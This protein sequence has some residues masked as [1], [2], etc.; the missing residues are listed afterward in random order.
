MPPARTPEELDQLL[1]DAIL[2][3][4]RTALPQ[5]FEQDALCVIGGPELRGRRLIARSLLE[6]RYVA[7]Q[8]H[9]LQRGGMALV[10]G[11]GS[12]HVACRH[13]NGWR[14]AISVLLPAER[15]TA[16][17]HLGEQRQA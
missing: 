1:E 3:R 13:G 15:A 4:D 2:L 11:A 8:Q 10:L 6:T 5:L 16:R 14:F 7:V 9:V 12:A 17:T